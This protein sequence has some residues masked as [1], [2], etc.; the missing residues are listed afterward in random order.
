MIFGFS[1]DC[2]TSRT[3]RTCRTE[4]ESRGSVTGSSDPFAFKFF[5]AG[6]GS[7]VFG[8]QFF[9]MLLDAARFGRSRAEKGFDEGVETPRKQ[10]SY[11]LLLITVTPEKQGTALDQALFSP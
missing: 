9:D 8:F 4:C 2:R 11:W 3:G 6:T 5:P 1:R 7:F 10:D